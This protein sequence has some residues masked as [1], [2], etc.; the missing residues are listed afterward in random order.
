MPYLIINNDDDKELRE[1]MR[2]QM[3][4]GYRR[5]LPMRRNATDQY[6][7]GY[8]NGYKHGYN[9]GAEDESAGMTVTENSRRRNS[10]GR[11]M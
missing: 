5:N 7:E 3:R 2:Q 11:F 8:R 1:N 10:S 9:D 6:E 4:G